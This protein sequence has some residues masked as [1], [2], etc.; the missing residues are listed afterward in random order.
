MHVQTVDFRRFSSCRYYNWK[1]WF[2]FHTSS[3]KHSLLHVA[4]LLH[5][6]AEEF[7]S[8]GVRDCCTLACAS[9]P[10]NWMVNTVN[11]SLCTWHRLSTKVLLNRWKNWHF[12]FAWKT[13][14]SGF[15]QGNPGFAQIPGLHGTL[16][17]CILIYPNHDYCKYFIQTHK[18]L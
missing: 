6:S 5:P 14:N 3:V 15:A 10:H 18:S 8:T 12:R 11:Y 7:Q 4:S 9:N 17:Q 13:W 2:C 16:L 1:I